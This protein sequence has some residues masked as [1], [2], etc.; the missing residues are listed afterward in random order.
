M[1][2]DW[3]ISLVY[4]KLTFDAINSSDGSGNYYA[5]LF[6]FLFFRVIKIYCRAWF[7]KDFFTSLTPAGFSENVLNLIKM[8]FAHRTVF[9]FHKRNLVSKWRFQ[10]SSSR[11]FWWPW[12]FHWLK[13][14][15]FSV[16]IQHQRIFSIWH[17]CTLRQSTSSAAILVKGAEC[18]SCFRR[19]IIAMMEWLMIMSMHGG[20]CT[21][22]VLYVVRGCVPSAF[23]FF[24]LFWSAL[25][26]FRQMYF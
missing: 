3:S 2:C 24:A 21:F 8:F 13:S 19:A 15:T 11:R 20:I 7:T 26:H 4:G 23:T 1:S 12:N 25:A 9:G 22:D 6:L 5:F 18:C 14:P 10:S 17:I 16:W